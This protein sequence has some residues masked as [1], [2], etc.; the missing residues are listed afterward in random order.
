MIEC[1][2]CNVLF[3]SNKG[4][5]LTNHILNEHSMS[6]EDYVVKVEYSGIAPKCA[7]GLC[8]LKPHFGRGKFSKFALK[9]KSFKVREKLFR[10]K[11]GD[12]VCIECHNFV[13]FFRGKPNKFCSS[14][15][16]GK[17]IGFSL[18]S[19]QKTI[20]ENNIKK[21]GVANIAQ[22]DFVKKRISQM[23]IGKG[24]PHTVES[25]K[26]IGVANSLKWRTAEYREKTIRN[27]RT[28]ILN[29][30]AERERRSNWL[31]Q[32]NKDASFRA[33]AF[34]NCR[35]RLSKLHRRIKKALNLEMFGFVSEQPILRYFVDELLEE[36]KLIIEI[37]G[38]YIHANPKKFTADYTIRLRG[39]SYTAKE[40]WASD[41]IRKEKLQAMGYKVFVIWESDNI[42]TI[43]LLLEHLLKQGSA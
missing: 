6:L 21:Y 41:K 31:K 40:K 16:S 24:H 26:K 8:N 35:N 5:Q 37:N 38:D 19:T 9:H 11:H 10:E 7:C 42:E 15:C 30:P 20:C 28:V 3:K 2:L 25:K 12:P 14:V 34:E 18:P 29:N 1:S 32:K 4:G 13:S 17:N 23:R 43:K 33:K 39:Q 27:I 22:V 36:K